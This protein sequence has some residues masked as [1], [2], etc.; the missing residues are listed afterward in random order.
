MNA[1]EEM[2]YIDNSSK[3]QEVVE[4]V[5]TARET[6]GEDMGIALDF[7]GRVHRAMTKDLFKEL[8]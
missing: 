8:S 4:R 7:H 5:A 3:I 2:Y 1:S 6:V